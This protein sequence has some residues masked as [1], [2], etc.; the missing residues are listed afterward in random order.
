MLTPPLPPRSTVLT[1]YDFPTA[2]SLRAA[3]VD[4]CLVGDSLANV[5]LGYDS[6]QRLTL[7]AMKHHVAAVVRG[8]SSPLLAAAPQITPKPLLI[9]DLPFGSYYASDDEGVRAAVELLQEAG[10]DGVKIEGGVEVVSLIKR[11]TSFG[12]PVMG[13]VGLQPQRA[14]ASSGF[15][16]QGRTCAEALQV[17]ADARAVQAAGAFAVVLECVPNR[18]GEE[19]SRLLDIPTVGI[20]AGPRT[21][22]QV[23][24]ANDMLG[25][26]T[27][28]GHI[29]AGLAASNASGG[30][31]R[32]LTLNDDA[33]QPPKFVRSFAAAASGGT[34]LGALRVAA[35]QAYVEAVRSRTFP[36]PDVEGYKMKKEE[37]EAFR[38]EL[39]SL[40]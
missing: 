8:L 30:E 34:S 27:G 3:D 24:V 37:F 28:P 31:T 22:G 40:A 18:V 21:D 14:T 38:K 7:G 5:A 26:L 29:L 4:V 1:A 23:L 9:A 12:I 33:P 39:A 11:L 2:L 17:Y 35:V 25:D 10:A 32:T 19:V 13:H 16:L 15:R 6:T 20:G 36:D